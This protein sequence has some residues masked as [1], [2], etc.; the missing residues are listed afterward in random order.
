MVFFGK[1]LGMYT[2]WIQ[3]HHVYILTI[4]TNFAVL[5]TL[6]ARRRRSHNAFIHGASRRTVLYS[7]FHPDTRTKYVTDL[8]SY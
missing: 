6:G 2:E 1:P 8:L 3:I 4:L 5:I 7:R